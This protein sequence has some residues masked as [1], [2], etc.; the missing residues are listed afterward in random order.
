MGNA[1]PQASLL[2]SDSKGLA[3]RGAQESVFAQAVL[4]AEAT[5]GQHQMSG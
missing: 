5:S 4:Y 2:D 3:G 1:D